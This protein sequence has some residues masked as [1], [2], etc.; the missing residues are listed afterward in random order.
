MSDFKL[1]QISNVMLGTTDLARSLAFYR[2]TLGLVVQFEMPGFVF[3]NA[4]GVTLSLSE[5]HAK[6]ATPGRRRHRGGVRGGG[7]HGGARGESVPRHRGS[8]VRST[9]RG[10]RPS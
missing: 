7:C 9:R 1:T 4:G 2:D 3:L 8:G 10:G 6:L 5:A